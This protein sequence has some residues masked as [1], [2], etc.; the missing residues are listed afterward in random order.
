MEFSLLNHSTIYLLMEVFVII[1]VKPFRK[2]FVKKNV[3][4]FTWLAWDDK[5]LTLKNLAK[6]KCNKLSTTTC[7]PCYG[8]I[9][10]TNH[11]FLHCPFNLWCNSEST[12]LQNLGMLY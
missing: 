5:I 7:V 12:F 2:D 11:M 6:K 4:A 9:E 1:L 8:V 3:K 10:S